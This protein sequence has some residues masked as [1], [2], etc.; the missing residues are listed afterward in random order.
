MA[1][2]RIPPLLLAQSDFL[3][4]SVKNEIE[5]KVVAKMN[6]DEKK[7]TASF[8]W[9]AIISSFGFAQYGYNIWVVYSPSVLIRDVYQL[10]PEGVEVTNRDPQHM[11]LI[12]AFS[13]SMFPI[14]AVA[15]ALLV[16]PMV[17]KFGR[18]GALVLNSFCSTIACLFMV[19]ANMARSFGFIMFSRFLMG[20]TMGVYS[21]TVPLYLTEISPVDSRGIIGMLPHFFL[22][23]GVLIAQILAFREIMGNAEGW[24][25]V[26]SLSGILA[27]FQSILMPAFPE[28]PRYLLIVKKDEE[29]ARQAL[30]QLRFNQDVEGEIEEIWEENAHEVEDEDMNALK[31]VCYQKLRWQVLS[32]IILMA[33]QQLSGVNSVYY[34]TERVYLSTNIGSENVRYISA[35]SS[36]LI[37]IG[38]G[39]ALTIVDSKG[40]KVLLLVGFAICSVLCIVLTVMIELQVGR[41]KSQAN[42]YFHA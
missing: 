12:M 38:M 28:S 23:L 18:K 7:L 19:G 26:M 40:R 34:Y 37:L 31:L 10:D 22:V 21:S 20:I 2:G 13:M 17:D 11:L 41:A 24:P 33:G 6:L 25:I 39:F 8:L 1:A 16:G 29:Q 14:G 30:K 3:I 42:T 5:G 4:Q 35:S 36:I 27:L 9:I 32:I 15:G